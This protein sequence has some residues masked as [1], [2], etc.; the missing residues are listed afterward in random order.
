MSWIRLWQSTTWG[1]LRMDL[2]ILSKFW[3][4]F[5][6][7]RQ[8]KIMTVFWTVNFL[9]LLILKTTWSIETT[10]LSRGYCNSWRIPNSLWKNSSFYRSSSWRQDW[11]SK[12]TRLCVVSI[13][14]IVVTWSF[15]TTEICHFRSLRRQSTAVRLC[16][17]HAVRDTKC[18]W[19]RLK[20]ISD[21]IWICTVICCHFFRSKGT[22]WHKSWSISPFPKYV[23]SWR[24]LSQTPLQNSSHNASFTILDRWSS[25]RKGTCN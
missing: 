12:H 24:S 4:S 2:T 16:C 13:T 7:S 17:S 25:R 8:F 9:Q 18:Y 3:C 22:G 14:S 1:S 15:R 10:M 11:T 23:L 21:W 19:C 6:K 20:N 5:T